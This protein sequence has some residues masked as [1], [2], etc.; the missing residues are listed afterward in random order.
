MIKVYPFYKHEL[1]GEVISAMKI[2]A[3]YLKFRKEGDEVA[4]TFSIFIAWVESSE[5][6]GIEGGNME[7]KILKI[8]DELYD[9]LCDEQREDEEEPE[10]SEDV[11]QNAYSNYAYWREHESDV[12][13][14]LDFD[15]WLSSMILNGFIEEIY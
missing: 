11:L 5:W 6:R 13:Y 8:N 1:S 9:A 15:E 14:I 2:Y 3:D 12:P 7:Y 4:E 10:V